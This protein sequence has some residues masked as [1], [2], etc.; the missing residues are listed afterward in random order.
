V[1]YMTLYW[2]FANEQINV[3][4]GKQPIWLPWNNWILCC[5]VFNDFAGLTIFTLLQDYADCG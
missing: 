1:V 3:F 4:E 2:I 5:G